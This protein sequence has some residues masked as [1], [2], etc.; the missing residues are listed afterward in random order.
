MV[1]EDSESFVGEGKL[2]QNGKY[3]DSNR[4]V[5]DIVRSIQTGGMLEACFAEH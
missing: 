4:G 2:Q 3:R 5:L 1:L